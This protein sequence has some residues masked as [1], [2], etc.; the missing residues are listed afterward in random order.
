[1]RKLTGNSLSG[2]LPREPCSSTGCC[3]MKMR[4]TTFA[5]PAAISVGLCWWRSI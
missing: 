1:L 5:N 4:M 3:G 2:N